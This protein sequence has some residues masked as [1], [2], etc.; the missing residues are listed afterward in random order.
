NPS[1][2]EKEVHNTSDTRI[3]FAGYVYG[4]D[5]NILMK[6]AYVYVQPSLIEGLSPVILTVM[7]LGTPLICSDIVENKFITGENA[8]HFTSGDA[9][10]LAEKINFSLNNEGRLKEMA[11][12]GREDI[13]TRFNWD[14]VTEKY[15]EL[16]NSKK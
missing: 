8:T 5:T 11:E 6:N 1:A 10:S 13:L 14:A 3:V 12:K 15:L 9:G 16:F 2:Y 7:G 4:D